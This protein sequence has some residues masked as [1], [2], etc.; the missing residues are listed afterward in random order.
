MEL[1]LTESYGDIQAYELGLS[2]RI[3]TWEKKAR[4][5]IDAVAAHHIFNYHLYLPVLQQ[6]KLIVVHEAC[7]A[8]GSVSDPSWW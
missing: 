1:A 6:V 4:I 3:G 7:V 8:G 2:F 5:A